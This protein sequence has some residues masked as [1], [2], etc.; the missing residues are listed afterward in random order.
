LT[1]SLRSLLIRGGVT[2]AIVGLGSSVAYAASSVPESDPT[3]AVG[4]LSVPAEDAVDR[5]EALASLSA[6]AEK[7]RQEKAA[8]DAAAAQAAAAAAAQ[9]QAEAAAKAAADAAAAQAAA[10][11]QEAARKA[12]AE[13][14]SRELA[15]TATTPDGAR[16]IARA[17]L[18]DYGWSDSQFTCLNNLW[19]RESNWNYQA[20]NTSSGAYGIP[21][22]LPAS[23]MASAGDDWRTNPA[24]QIKWGLGYIQDVY[25]SPCGAWSHSQSVGWY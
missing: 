21:Q 1:R 13:A 12:A 7:K 5:E 23:K 9:A 2:V 20:R 18:A 14:A 6:V 8:A 19:T 4:A 10:D 3:E 22:S 24:T 17:M 25:G 11:A 15:R 16:A